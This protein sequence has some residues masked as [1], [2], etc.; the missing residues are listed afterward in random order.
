MTYVP[1]PEQ[2]EEINKAY[3]ESRKGKIEDQ[4]LTRQIN[5]YYDFRTKYMATKQWGKEAQ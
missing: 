2:E 5:R 3:E 1:T 4:S